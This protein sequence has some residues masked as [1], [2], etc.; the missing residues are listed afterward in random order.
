MNT[1]TVKEIQQ[2]LHQAGVA[3]GEIDGVWGRRTIAAVKVFQAMSGLEEDGIVGPKTSALLFARGAP[4]NS[5]PLLPWVA[6]AENLMGTTE[7]LGTRH[8]PEI[9]DWSKSL[10]IHYPGDEIPWCGLFV[11]HCVGAT[12]PEELLPSNPLGA[13]RWERFGEAS[14]PRYGAIMVFWRD[15]PGSGK[16]HVGFYTGEDTD[17]YRI[18][19]GNQKNTVSVA[20]I[21]KERFTK[22]RWPRTGAYLAGGQA[23]ILVDRKEDLSNVES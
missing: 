18:L 21:S 1:M 8:N 14:E 7:I 20:W 12:I 11:A 15:S 19:G 22:A 4:R 5:A 6:E 10:D 9:M 23:A 17:A 16:G 13:R 3:V 2:A